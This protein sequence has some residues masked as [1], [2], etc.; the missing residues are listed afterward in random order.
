MT[1]FPQLL[2]PNLLLFLLATVC[3]AFIITLFKYRALK[4]IASGRDCGVDIPAQPILNDE[5]DVAQ[6]HFENMPCGFAEHELIFDENGKAIDFRTLHVNPTFTSFTGVEKD[7][8]GSSTNQ[9]YPEI[10][11]LSIIDQYSKVVQNNSNLITERYVPAQNRC[12]QEY[13]FCTSKNRFATLLTEQTETKQLEHSLQMERRQFKMLFE[14][15]PEAA[16]I[17]DKTHILDCNHSTLSLLGYQH[18]EELQGIDHREL[19]PEV[20][21]D[22]SPSTLIQSTLEPEHYHQSDMLLYKSDGQLFPATV[23]LT[24]TSF[25]GRRIYLAILQDQTERTQIENALRTSEERLT[26]A[27]IASQLGLWDWDLDTGELYVSNSWLAMIG[28]SPQ[29]EFEKTGDHFFQLIHPDDKKAVTQEVEKNM[30]G[31]LDYYQAQFRLLCKDGSYKWVH[32]AGQVKERCN[33][34]SPTR[35][36]GIHMDIS[37]TIRL[38][39]DLRRAKDEAEAADQAKSDFLANMSHEIRTPLNAIIGMGFMMEKTELTRKQSEYLRKMQTSANLLFETINDILDFSKI[40]ADALTLETTEFMLEDILRDVGDVNSDN[41]RSKGLEMLYSFPH[42]TIPPLM[43]DPLRLSQILN[44]LISNAIKFTETGAVVLSYEIINQTPSVVTINFAVKDTGIGLSKEQQKDLFSAFSQADGSTTRKF[45]GTGLGLSICKQLITLMDGDIMVESESGKGARF[46]FTIKFKTGK[47]EVNKTENISDLTSLNVLVVD[48]SPEV[49]QILQKLLRKQVRKTSH[50][51]TAEECMQI[52]ENQDDPIDLVLLDRQLPNYDGLEVC[53]WIKDHKGLIKT[54]K[55]II[56]SG[57]VEDTSV[58]STANPIY[59]GYLQKPFT[60]SL[61]NKTIQNAFKSEQEAAPKI[62][63]P[64][65]LGSL[66]QDLGKI[67][68]SRILLV[69]DNEL[70]QDVASEILTDAG[71]K[72]SIA[73]DGK[74]ALKAAYE[75]SFDLILMDIQMPVMDGYEATRI[76]RSNPQFIKLPILAI[77]ANATERDQKLSALA[78]MNEHLSKPIVPE[79]LFEALIRWIPA[80]KRAPSASSAVAPKSSTSVVIP[81]I[82]G[83]NIEKGLIRVAGKRDLYLK[84]IKKFASKYQTATDDIRQL[85]AN[86]ELDEASRLAHSMKGVAGMIGAEAIHASTEKLEKEIKKN[87]QNIEEQL[88]RVDDTLHPLTQSIEEKLM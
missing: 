4:Q 47:Q 48:D 24:Q 82:D 86:N 28:Y 66:D 56:C 54:P 37:E 70:N 2:S 1:H 46:S 58:L 57:L 33:L 26:S 13:I 29:D 8:L 59:D 85:L 17:I 84:T 83:L 50:T 74:Q 18:K 73:S 34:G 30:T 20:Q 14:Q 10:A 65:N 53:K 49:A 51:L 41:A 25:E 60:R 6:C 87:G 32:A 63:K 12:F 9:L 5:H 77:T 22:N 44:N 72:V 38:Q 62:E 16:L 64:N 15:S 40:T 80:K 55:V 69:E 67:I 78:G 7:T 39:E 3:T 76:L 36:V 19:H 79:A 81:E 75:N 68:G 88:L 43:G 27:F 21:P 61:I 71:F 42:V 11:P 52:I 31:Q 35:M 45:G 23:K